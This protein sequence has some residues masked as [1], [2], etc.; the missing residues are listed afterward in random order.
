M[1]FSQNSVPFGYEKLTRAYVLEHL[2]QLAAWRLI[3]GFY[4]NLGEKF[5]LPPSFRIDRRPGCFLSEFNGMIYLADFRHPTT[6]SMNIFSAVMHSQRLNFNEALIYLFDNLIRNN[7]SII[8]S[9]PKTQNQSDFVFL[10]DGVPRKFNYADKEFWEQFEISKANLIYEDLYPVDVL[11]HNTHANKLVKIKPLDPCYMLNVMGRKKSYRPYLNGRGKWL[12]NFNAST[13]GGKSEIR[14]TSIAFI[15]KS[16][17]DYQ[18]ITNA[19]F[20]SRYIHSEGIWPPVEFIFSLYSSFDYVVWLMD[21]DQ[22]GRE[23]AVRLAL[24]SNTITNSSKFIPMWPE[25]KD[26]AVV[27]QQLG[28]NHYK[29]WLEEQ[30]KG[31][32]QN[33]KDYPNA[34]LNLEHQ[35]LIL[36]PAK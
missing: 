13:I 16:Y 27:V 34:H 12:S 24:Y 17:K 2:D 28:F 22:A 35:E 36:A 11:I 15:T 32:L 29:R 19:G 30:K 31:I 23:A 4:V 20:S 10:L 25:L 33:W 7:T 8:R 18:V 26:S 9:K 1:K 3:L 6:H 5:A 21:N 14:D